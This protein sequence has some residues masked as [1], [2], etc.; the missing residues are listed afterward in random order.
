MKETAVQ[1]E[2]KRKR[3]RDAAGPFWLA[4][5]DGVG[6]IMKVVD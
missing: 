3:A 4:G 6:P 1:G 5:S 2:R